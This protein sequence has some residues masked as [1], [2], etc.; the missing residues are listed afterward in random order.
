[1]SVVSRWSQATNN[2]TFP[3][4]RPELCIMCQF[5]Q[6]LFNWN[7]RMNSPKVRALI[8]CGVLL[9]LSPRRSEASSY[10]PGCAA[11]LVGAAIGVGAGIGVAIYFVHRSHT[12]LTGC[13][14]Q[15]ANE[16]ALSAKDGASY[17]LVN[18]PREVK[19]G[20]RL[21]LRGHKINTGS[22]RAF[23]VDRVAHDDGACEP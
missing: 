1:M 4:C 7:E 10:C 8:L 16:F 21:S 20:T 18:A 9:S 13:V 17:T 15:S 23:R 19:A 14:S 2:S 12:S 11:A 5:W 3:V 6:R 22:G